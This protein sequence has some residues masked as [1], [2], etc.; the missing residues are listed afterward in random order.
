[1]PVGQIFAAAA[2][3]GFPVRPALQ[4]Q[5]ARLFVQF[6]LHVTAE[7]EIAAMGNS[8]QLAIFARGQKGKCVLNIRGSRGVVT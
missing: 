5:G 1:M 3:F 2:P 6:A 7:I 8:F 4:F